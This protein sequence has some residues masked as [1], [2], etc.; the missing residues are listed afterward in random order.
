MCDGGGGSD[1]EG[2]RSARSS[3]AAGSALSARSSLEQSRDSSTTIPLPHHMPWHV[4]IANS[5]SCR[6]NEEGLHGGEVRES[7]TSVSEEPRKPLFESSATS[8]S[9]D[10]GERAPVAPKWLFF[11]HS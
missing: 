6:G 3:Y 9:Q 4:C 8:F 5:E 7:V 11:G 2:W 10:E 1:G